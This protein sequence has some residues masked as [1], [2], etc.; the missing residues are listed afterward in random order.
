MQ[1]DRVDPRVTRTVLALKRAIIDLASDRPASKITVA[2][3]ADAAG[4][5]RATFYNRYQSPLELLLDVLSADL[6]EGLRVKEARRADGRHNAEQVL[7]LTIGDVADHVTRFAAVYRHAIADPA[8]G[9][10]YEVLVRC[11]TERASAVIGRSAPPGLPD[12]SRQVMIKF[13]AYGFAGAVKAW[14]GDDSMT[15][16]DLIEASVACAPAWWN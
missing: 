10:V 1:A 3:V 15:R 4:V 13:F 14:L 16:A 7:R 2:D 9:G 11:F 5:T 8:D 12:A 6:D